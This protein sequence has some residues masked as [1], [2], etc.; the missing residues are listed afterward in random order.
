MNMRLNWQKEEDY[1]T[2]KQGLLASAVEIKHETVL[3][4]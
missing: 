3:S 4:R 1:N 2:A